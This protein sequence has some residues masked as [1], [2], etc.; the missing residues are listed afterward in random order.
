[1]KKLLILLLATLLLLASCVEVEESKATLEDEDE[2]LSAESIA[3]SMDESANT[4]SG[5]TDWRDTVDAID[6]GGEPYLIMESEDEWGHTFDLSSILFDR[7]YEGD[8]HLTI[9]ATTGEG[10]TVNEIGANSSVDLHGTLL[11]TIMTVEIFESLHARLQ[12]ESNFV[13]T[14][15]VPEH[16]ERSAR[17]FL[18][19][20]IYYDL[21]DSTKAPEILQEY[22]E[23]Y[24]FLANAPAYVLERHITFSEVS[25]ITSILEAY[26]LDGEIMNGY[27]VQ[28]QEYLAEYPESLADFN[29]NTYKYLYMDPSKVTEVTLPETVTYIEMGAFDG[30]DNLQKVN[31]FR[32]D[33][34]TTVYIPDENGEPEGTRVTFDDPRLLEYA[35]ESFYDFLRAV[36]LLT[37]EPAA[38]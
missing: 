25:R 11:P 1:M 8:I 32:M 28:M 22:E 30:Y 12:D 23:A 5:E 27:A 4:P 33:M 2:T 15:A 9:P 36:G 10:V 7:K 37:E 26:G 6:F 24:P 38:N 31:G 17:L 29:F 3:E 19:F 20:F 14:E 34:Q 16:I 13:P 18:A 21:E 35:D